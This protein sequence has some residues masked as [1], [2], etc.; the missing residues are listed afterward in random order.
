[1]I[2]FESHSQKIIKRKE[3]HD[4]SLGKI[5]SNFHIVEGTVPPCFHFK[6]GGQ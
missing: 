2:P 6:R 5:K 3:R 1:M 4:V